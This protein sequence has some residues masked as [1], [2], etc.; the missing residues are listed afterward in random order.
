[1]P[2]RFHPPTES[3]TLNRSL[4]GQRSLRGKGGPGESPLGKPRDSLSDT[5]SLPEGG[6]FSRE[7]WP[8]SLRTSD[9]RH[10]RLPLREVWRGSDTDPH[11]K[12]TDSGTQADKQMGWCFAMLLDSDTD[13]QAE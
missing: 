4:R 1:M 12:E 6:L 13:R 3:A 10:G 11:L 7:K 2:C 9:Q 5:D 8:G